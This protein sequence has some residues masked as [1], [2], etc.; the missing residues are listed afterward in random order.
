MKL[1]TFHRNMTRSV[2]L[3]V[4]VI[5][6]MFGHVSAQPQQDEDAV[7]NIVIILDASG[8]MS[9]AMPG[10]RQ[11]KMQAA[12]EALL[13]VTEQINP[14]TH[15]GLLVFS[16]TNKPWDW[17]YPLGPL[18]IDKFTTNLMQIL[19]SG[20]TPLG[21]YIKTG[22]DRLL[23]KRAEQ[24]G[25]GTYRLLIVTDGQASDSELVKAYTPVA[26][27]RGTVIDV[28]GV[29]MASDHILATRVHS[30]RKAD[31]SKSLQQ[32]IS[33][34]VAEI[35]SAKDDGATDDDSFAIINALPDGM[36]D[37][38]LTALTHTSNEPIQASSAWSGGSSASGAAH[39]ASPTHAPPGHK[40]SGPSIVVIIMWGV[41]IL[42]AVKIILAK[43][44]KAFR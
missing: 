44:K 11:T 23:E 30:Y 31:D 12:K 28:I 38:L 15:V 6:L 18:D 3:V 17:V 5:L 33:A 36:A 19:P 13:Q 29:A 43:L 25:Y 14:Q 9:D 42:I 34:S 20:G 40:P 37:Q 26:L 7:D 35:S 2:A 32:A 21:A 27:A 39:T 4:A 8:S 1:T 24:H 10:S 22:T 41:I 16:G